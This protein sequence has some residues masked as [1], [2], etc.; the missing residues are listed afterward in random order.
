MGILWNIVDSD[1]PRVRAH[2]FYYRAMHFNAKGGLA[3]VCPSATLVDCD[4]LGWKS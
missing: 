2:E 4:R 3:I 1:A